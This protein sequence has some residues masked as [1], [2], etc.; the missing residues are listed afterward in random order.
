MT[1]RESHLLWLKDLLQ[2][3]QEC[4]DQL[5]W[6]EDPEAA[7]VL[8][9]SILSDL[10]CGKKVCEAIRVRTPRRRFAVVSRTA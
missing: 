3:L 4:R 9:D 2:H 7:Q 5:E 1:Q 8:I 6:A 10:E